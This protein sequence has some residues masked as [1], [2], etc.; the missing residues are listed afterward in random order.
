ML[1]RLICICHARIRCIAKT[2]A[3]SADEFNTAQHN[4]HLSPV[5][6]GSIR[7]T[8][9]TRKDRFVSDTT[10]ESP[11]T[12]PASGR[13]G[14]GLSSMLLPE[15]QAYAV[16]LGITGTARMRKGQLIEAIQ[17]KNNGGAAK[18]EPAAPARAPRRTRAA[19][20]AESGTTEQG[21]QV[22][23]ELV[24]AGFGYVR[25][26]RDLAG[27]ERVTEAQHGQI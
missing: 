1:P 22:R 5:R 13:A 10:T 2:T 24:L 9:A 17:E 12:A 20:A 14:K 27:H 25:S 21:E 3:T 26:H 6:G 19:V 16:S 7:L 4:Q 8:P 18:A 11:A 23:A 15:L